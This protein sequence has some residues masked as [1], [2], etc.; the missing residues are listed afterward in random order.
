VILGNVGKRRVELSAAYSH[1]FS[2]EK[3][4][5]Q[6]SL[7]DRRKSKRYL[8][9]DSCANCVAI[10]G[11]REFQAVLS[12]TSAC[13]FG[14]MLLTGVPVDRDQQLRLIT[15][16]GIHDC[17]ITHTRREESLLH[18]GVE[19]LSD[20]S[21]VNLPSRQRSKKFFRFGATGASPFVFI[22]VVLGFTSVAGIIVLGMDMANNSDTEE[23]I[24][25]DRT[26]QHTAEQH[27]EIRAKTAKTAKSSIRYIDNYFDELTI[28]QRVSFNSVVTQANFGWSD[29]VSRLKLTRTQQ[30]S[31][32]ELIQEQA[33]VQSSK[34]ERF[35]TMRDAIRDVLEE[36]QQQ[37]FDLMWV[38]RPQNEPK[39]TNASPATT[40][41]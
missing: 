28:E 23:V 2:F 38:V 6:M 41:E 14:L 36:N 17:R 16:D 39:E 21:L 18:V 29:L 20:V 24:I 37:R 33:G 3:E 9:A 19:R 10:V 4:I 22:A 40:N 26:P 25:V 34:E 8:V 27:Q 15:G 7:A 11:N 35:N 12:D 13:G 30:R 5:Q 1:G 32:I 31:V